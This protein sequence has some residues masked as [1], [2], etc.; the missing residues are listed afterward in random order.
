VYSDR[1]RVVLEYAE[2]A[3]SMPVEVSDEFVAWLHE[4]FSDAEIVE[5]AAWVAW[6]ENCRS[7]FNAGLGLKSQRFSD[8]RWV[9]A[10]T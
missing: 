4:H 3:S 10:T 6:K 1:E 9:S 8:H 7:R 2:A 5:P